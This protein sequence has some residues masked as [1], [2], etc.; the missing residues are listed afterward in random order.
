MNTF[1]NGNFYRLVNG[2]RKQIIPATVY[3]RNNTNIAGNET[4]TGRIIDLNSIKKSPFSLIACVS[5]PTYVGNVQVKLKIEA[6]L[7]TTTGTY[8]W[9]E[10]TGAVATDTTISDKDSLQ[11][12]LTNSTAPLGKE[13]VSVSPKLSNLSVMFR[14]ANTINSTQEI[15]VLVIPTQLDPMFADYLRVSLVASITGTGSILGTFNVLGLFDSAV[16]VIV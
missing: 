16:N 4:I 1:D 13:D 3:D 11:L 8:V 15:E 6:G 5:S 12:I 14:N 7:K 9:K 2:A 10:V